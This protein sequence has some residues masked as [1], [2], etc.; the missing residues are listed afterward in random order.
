MSVEQLDEFR[1][2]VE[3]QLEAEKKLRK[4]E[5]PA[6]DKE[7]SIEFVR[8][9][10]RT[11]EVGD[12]ML[13]NFLHRDRFVANAVTKD[14]WMCYVA[15]HWEID[16][17]KK[18]KAAV[19]AVA[20]QYLRLLAPIDEELDKLND[21]PEENDRRKILLTKRK[22][23]LARLDRL[24]SDRGRNAVL[25]CAASNDEPLSIHPDK[26]D[27]QP[28]LFPCA[29]GVIDLRTGEFLEKGDPKL[30]LTIASPT[31]WEGINASCPHFEQF[32]RDV[33]DNNQEV[34]DYLQ[35]VLGYTITGLH[36]ERIFVVLFGPHGQNG[37]GTLIYTLDHVLGPLS[38]MVATELLMSQRFTKSAASP[39][40]ELMDFKGKRMLYASETEEKHSFAAGQLKRFSGGDKVKGRGLNDKYHVEFESTH[41]L[42]LLCNDLPTAPAKDDPFW[43]RIKVFLFPF[44]F[45]PQQTA[46][47]HRPVDPAMEENLKKEASGILAWLVRGCL[48]WQQDGHLIP[49][50]KVVEDSARYRENED[51]LQ[52][53]LDECCHVNMEDASVDNRVAASAIYQRFRV[54][55]EGN[56]SI[57]PIN[58]KDFSNQ[59]QLKGF[60]KLKSGN[61]YYQY[62]TLKLS[63]EA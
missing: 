16:Y 31:R 42:F 10:Y 3:A 18:S 9:C 34:I 54:W 44:S 52:H 36:S 43:T 56:N 26:F 30:Y 5:E 38:S 48:K 19:E 13:Y 45:L 6:D 35:K 27:Q 14:E 7:P 37:K 46:P 39:S 12:S 47:H 22:M 58:Q 24:R 17:H 62:L 59:L 60:V 29:N 15:P 53:F 41:V 1:K 57:R 33:L 20:V 23:L 11:N 49:P 2:K 50:A 25:N 32:L 55:W 21:G 28:W 63:V 8:D 40:P 4:P 51:Y 61:L